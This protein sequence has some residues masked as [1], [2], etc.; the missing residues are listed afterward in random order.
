MC[1]T[2][3][4]S[5][6]LPV[7][8][9]HSRKRDGELQRG[10]AVVLRER[11]IGE[12]AVELADLP[13]VQDLRV[14]QRVRVLDG[15]ARDVVEDHVHDADRP[16]GAVRVLAVEG[17]VVRVL[18]LLLHILVAL[19]QEAAGADGGVVD[20]LPGAR[21]HE[22]HE[23]A[24]DFA[25]RVELAALL[26]GAVG[27]VLDQVF[28]GG[29]EQVGELEVVVDQ[30][31]L[32]LVE[33][34]EQVLPF[35]VGDLGLAL[36]RVEVDVVLQHAGERV[37]LVLDGGDGLVEHVADVV[38]EVLERRNLVAV[39]VRPGLV[40]AGAD[41]HEEGLAV[42]GL[43]FEQLVQER[44]VGDVGEVLLAE[45]ARACGRIRRTGASGRAC[46]R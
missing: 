37:V 42:G 24:D 8:G 5:A 29:A 46:R 6:F 30:H 33:V 25:G 41:G 36:D 23:Q 11:R 44:G 7:S 3:M 39:L 14:L 10:A 31:E 45:N 16:D 22:L 18:A 15:E 35:L 19:D 20:L 34:V 2:N 32:R 1:W 17:E 28:V 43:V 38:L 12:D 13:V 4:R 27:E 40:P 21:L 9:H 26:A